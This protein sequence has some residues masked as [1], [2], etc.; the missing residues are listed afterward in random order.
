MRSDSEIINHPRTADGS[1]QQGGTDED[2]AVSYVSSPEDPVRRREESQAKSMETVGR[3][4]VR[5]HEP[6]SK[7]QGKVTISKLLTKLE[8][9]DFRCGLT[10]RPLTPETVA[11]DHIKP[12]S[13]GG[14]HCIDNVW[15]V[16]TDANRAKGTMELDDFIALCCDVADWSR[17]AS[18]GVD[19]G[20]LDEL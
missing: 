11:A 14:G 20:S 15:L 16:H 9:Q 17:L 7:K 13:K 6:A 10:G 5:K 2:M 12:V 8:S 19:F 18:L 1:P 4:G 3:D